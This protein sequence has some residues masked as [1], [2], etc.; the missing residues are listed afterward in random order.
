MLRFLV[1]LSLAAL[2]IIAFVYA[3]AS[4]NWFA[5]P[6]F[7]W[8]IMIALS[9]LTT[10]VFY[11]LLAYSKAASFTQI[12]LLS[13]VCKLLGYGT[14][15]IVFILKDKAGATE[16]AVLFMATYFIFTSIEVGLLFKKI[17]A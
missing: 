5:F 3:G 7:F 15:M 2:S 17:N 11:F 16:N 1:F 10:V 13:I 6:S 12:Y 9:F 14:I 8:A 4:H